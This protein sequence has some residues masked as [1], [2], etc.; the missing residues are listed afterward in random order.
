MNQRPFQTSLQTN[1][2]ILIKKLRHVTFRHIVYQTNIEDLLI[3]AV[4]HGDLQLLISNQS[5]GDLHF[6]DEELLQWATRKGYLH[7]IR[8]L[9][10]EQGS[11][12]HA[13]DDDAFLYAVVSGKL[14]ITKYFV[15]KG[16][17]INAR[18][19]IGDCA[20]RWAVVFNYFDI[21]RY[22][23]DQGAD[24]H[25]SNEEP[26][27]LAAH[28]G[29]Y[30]MTKLLVNKG[31]NIHVQNNSPLKLCMYSLLPNSFDILKFLVERGASIDVEVSSPNARHTRE[32]LKEYKKQ[33][34]KER[35]ATKLVL[36][37]IPGLNDDVID[38]IESFLYN[39]SL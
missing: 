37:K 30:E 11:D 16:A 23:I 32:R 15:E 10:E 31:A 24:I 8:Y 6:N 39:F 26:L 28:N 33:L 35:I 34:I 13:N 19:T 25:Y 2:Q 22:L 5:Y 7:I 36:K 29:R 17:N 27:L 9:V 20:L 38:E 3:H 1:K 18:N 4:C 21:L 12:I 14:E